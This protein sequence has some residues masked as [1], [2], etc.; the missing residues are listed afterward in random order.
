MNQHHYHHHDDASGERFVPELMSGDLIDAEHQARYRFALEHVAGKRVLDAGCGV[1]WGSKLILE[2]GAASVVGV[3]ISE[4]ALADCRQRAPEVD[5]V[6]GDLQELS[7]GDGE[8]DIVVC[9]EALEHVEDTSSA[10]DELTRVLSEDGILFVSSPNP[11]V[12]PEGNHF[13]LHELDP[14]ELAKEVADRLP[15]TVMFLQHQM[16][17]SILTRTP[18]SVPAGAFDTRTHSV[19]G[20]G[21]GNDAYSVAVASRHPVPSLASWTCVAPLTELERLTEERASILEQLEASHQQLRD[22]D[23]ALRGVMAERDEAVQRT[24]D[25]HTQWEATNVQLNNQRAVAD[26]AAAERDD[27]AVRLVRAS[28]STPVP[29]I[30]RDAPQESAQIARLRSKLE[31]ARGNAKRARQR[32]ASLQDQLDAATSHRTSRNR[33]ERLLRRG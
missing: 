30:T 31:R 24:I 22:A 11:A 10:L 12:Y 19:T 2:A 13:H 33:L 26:A 3:D 21:H 18:D 17:A 29:D 16:V 5:F 20:W 6:Q 14:D 8:F 7:F 15:H 1:G 32:A 25:L 4:E 27:L 28:R 23:H 9:F